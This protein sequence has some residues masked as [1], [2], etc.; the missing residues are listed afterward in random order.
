MQFSNGIIL[1]MLFRNPIPL[2]Y[3]ALIHKSSFIF[4]NCRFLLVDD[5]FPVP[6]EVS[7]GETLQ[8]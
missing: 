2:M 1:H 3:Y 7:D 4:I 8:A 6:K 5:L